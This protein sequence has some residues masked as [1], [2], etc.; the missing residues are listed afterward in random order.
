[1][2]ETRPADAALVVTELSTNAVLHTDGAAFRVTLA[3]G[4]EALLVSV[5]DGG[6]ACT[7]PRV[8]KPGTEVTHGRGLALVTALADAVHLHGDDGR[9]H[10]VVAE[11]RLSPAAAVPATGHATRGAAPCR[12]PVRGVTAPVAPARAGAGAAGVGGQAEAGWVL[13][14]RAKA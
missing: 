4:T 13:R 8:E 5:T 14:V 1:M 10:T 11:L 7:A 12:S 9:G 3:P 6:G 2:P